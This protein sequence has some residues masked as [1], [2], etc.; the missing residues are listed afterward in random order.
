MLLGARGRQSVTVAGEEVPVGAFAELIA[1]AAKEAG[2]AHH[3]E[4]ITESSEDDSWL[5]G[6]DGTHLVDVSSA[7]ERSGCL[8]AEL[9]RD[10]A[11]GGWELGQYDDQA[12]Y[13]E[14]V[15]EITEVES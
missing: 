12:I 13:T 5:T 6:R 9:I 7:A 4:T 8:L 14:P 10:R 1:E 3:T 11:E 2:F 15:Y